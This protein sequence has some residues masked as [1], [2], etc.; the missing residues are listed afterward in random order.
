MIKYVSILLLVI[1]PLSA[2]CAP[3]VSSAKTENSQIIIEGS[4]FGNSNPMIFWDDTSVAYSKLLASE[5]RDNVAPAELWQEITNAWGAPFTI[6][7]TVEPRSA[8]HD[9]EPNPVYFGTGHKNFLGQ[10]VY[11]FPPKTKDTLYV[12]WWYKPGMHPNAEGASNKF[13]RIWDDKNGNGTRV[14]WTQMHLTCN[15]AAATW[16]TWSGKVN[17]WNHHEFYIN[18]PEKR[19]VAKV[20]GVTYHDVKNCEKNPKFADK[21][22]FV[23]LLGF[24]HGSSS[25]K[26]MTTTIDDI[27]IGDSQARVVVSNSA[28]WENNM[29]TE[30]LP[31]REWKDN[32][33]VAQDIEG[34][35]VKKE[36]RYLYVIL[37]D[38][39]VN[40]NGLALCPK[41]PN[42]PKPL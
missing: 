31:I 4:G 32:K 6:S 40:K 16:R 7:A 42:E 1:T 33:I 24:D 37:E 30:V 8:H 34:F 3:T 36:K 27:Y 28:R 26:N 25:Y 29:E 9:S 41:C 22:I 14:S 13:I 15:D 19:V 5:G 2:I 18:M 38:G 10:P 12:S 20:N 39:S 21:P 35:I 17:E 11:Q 23:E